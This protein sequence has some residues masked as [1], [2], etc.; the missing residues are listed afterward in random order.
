VKRLL[1]Q[2]YDYQYGQVNQATGAV[3]AQKNNG[4]L[5]RTDAFIGGTPQSPAKQW[6]ERFSYDSLARLDVASEYR[7]DTGALT[8]RADYD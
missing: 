6:E 7:G 1:L 3:D 5:G 4:Q 2:R 8:W